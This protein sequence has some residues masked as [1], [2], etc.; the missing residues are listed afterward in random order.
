MKYKRAPFTEILHRINE[1]RGKMQVIVGP[2][3]VGK[4][5]LIGQILEE[6]TLPFDSYSADDVTG[7]SADWL[8]QVWES[9]RMKMSARGESKRLMVIDEIQKIKN[10]SETV[11]AEWDRDTREKREL[12]IVLLGSSRMLIEKGLTESLAGRFELIRLSHWTYTEMKDCFGWSLQQY[13][14]FGGYPGAA[15]FINNENR[16]RNYVKDSLI[17]PS[18]S[19]DILMDT[20]IMKPQL[21]RQLFE[22]GSSY[23]GE[24]LSLT[25]IAAQLQDTGN[26]T[27]LAG[28]LHLL[29]ECGLLCGL[30]KFAE[31]DARK[32]N[33]VPKFQVHNNAL[34]NVYIDDDFS[35]VIEDPK[36]WGRYIES[37]IGA[38]LVSQAQIN[39]YKVYYWRDHKDEVDFILVRR[40]KKIAIEVKSGRRTTNQGISVFTKTYKPYKALIIGSGGLSFEEFLSMD[41]NLLFK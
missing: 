25:K 27:T 10:W 3:Q 30:Q 24:L 1:P 22:L 40:K 2:R 28:Y 32:Y 4:S 33:S 29:D 17:E 9:Q 7:V 37:A 35:E 11:K 6:C 8:A 21:L 36:L 26:V 16:W 13:V 23:S 39:D 15:Q 31:D 20:K 5:T 14:Y 19:K 38:Y 18:I 34:R 12:V 41:I